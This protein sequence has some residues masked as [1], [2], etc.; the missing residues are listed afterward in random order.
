MLNKKIIEFSKYRLSKAKEE[1]E[2]AKELVNIGKYSQSINR[3]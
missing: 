1:L 3:S 2:T